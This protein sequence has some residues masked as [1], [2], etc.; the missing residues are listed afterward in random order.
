MTFMSLLFFKQLLS[1]FF[2]PVKEELLRF[3]Y[4]NFSR[5]AIFGASHGGRAVVPGK[6]VP[7]VRITLAS[8]PPA[9]TLSAIAMQTT[10]T[11]FASG[12][13]LVFPEHGVGSEV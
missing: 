4:R 2:H 13:N 10:G 6:A 12:D 1:L 8:A 3:P 5:V 11:S 7:A 9:T